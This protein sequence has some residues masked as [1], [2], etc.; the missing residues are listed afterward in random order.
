MPIAYAGTNIIARD[1]KRLVNFYVEVFE[2]TPVP[3]QRLLSGRWLEDGTG[4]ENASLEGMHL[5]LPG[6]GMPAL[7]SEIYSY[8]E[9]LESPLPTNRCGFT[10][11]ALAADD[12]EQ[13]LSKVI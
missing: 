6:S 10:H 2:C 11:I 12:V 5:R 4:L 8:A 7:R 3:P 1:W 13:M 9:T